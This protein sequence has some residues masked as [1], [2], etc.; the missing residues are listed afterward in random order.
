M[1]DRDDKARYS[2]NLQGEVDSAGLY[3]ALAEAEPNP[4]LSQ[5]YRRLATIEDAHAEY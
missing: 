3:R 1:G 5:V 2:S 4:Q